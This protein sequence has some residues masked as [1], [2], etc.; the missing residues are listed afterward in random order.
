MIVSALRNQLGCQAN[1]ETTCAIRAEG[2]FGDI[3]HGCSRLWVPSPPVAAAIFGRHHD[4]VSILEFA[5]V[6]NVG[7]FAVFAGPA[8]GAATSLLLSRRSPFGLSGIREVCLVYAV[9]SQPCAR[10]P[11]RHLDSFG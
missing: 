7:S 4:Q 2:I 3:D 10:S 9:F 1:G 8:E 5:C 11:E 6:N